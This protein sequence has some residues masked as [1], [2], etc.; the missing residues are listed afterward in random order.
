MKT[1]KIKID[2]I[3][4]DLLELDPS[5]KDNKK[6]LRNTIEE[7]LV[8]K[9]KPVFNKKFKD[10]LKKELLLK[11]SENAEEKVSL[12]QKIGSWFLYKKLRIVLSS[13]L[14]ILIILGIVIIRRDY[15]TKVYYCYDVGL[16]E[17]QKFSLDSAKELNKMMSILENITNYIQM[18]DLDVSAYAK[19]VPSLNLEDRWMLS[20]LNSFVK[21]V[22][23]DYD[24]FRWHLCGRKFFDFIV[25]D[26]SRWYIK[27]VRERSGDKDIASEY[28]IS[29]VLNVAIKLMAPITPYISEYLYVNNFSSV[30]NFIR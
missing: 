23:E 15:N 8:L 4:S 24:T 6:E 16:W 5:L 1:Q 27:L 20:R 17:T 9:P 22:R 13:T 30:Q 11:F 12:F 3:L 14:I 29:K 26:F 19:K 2:K 25:N 18:Y 21:E 10:N 7:L 28:V